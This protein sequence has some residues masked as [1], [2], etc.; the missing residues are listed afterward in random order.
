MQSREFPL[1]FECSA[2]VMMGVLTRPEN[3]PCDGRPGIVVIVGGPQY[4]VGS[5]RQFVLQARGWG[6]AG[7]TVLRFDYRGMGDSGGAGRTFESVA[8][9][10]RGAIDVLLDSCPDLVGVV[11]FGLCDGAS[12]ALMYAPE[13][14]RV[15][16]LMLL[17]PWVRTV[18]SE[19]RATLSHYYPR[20]VFQRSFWKKLFGG[21]IGLRRVASDLWEILRRISRSHAPSPQC[22]GDFRARMLDGL[23]QYRGR[24]AIYLSSDDLVAA[25]FAALCEARGPWREATSRHS[26]KTCRLE[27]A[28]HSL[29]N[30]ADVPAFIKI[31][32][33]WLADQFLATGHLASSK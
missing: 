4:R 18:E 32:I 1:V 7:W 19:A 24:V 9:D 11:L 33:R 13:D 23:S 29:S 31:S 30:P 10:I 28:D 27:G 5:H 25:E 17:N 21:G 2:S 20:R 12:A 22:V 15:R 8:D 16:G 6:E 26:V 3:P 14:A